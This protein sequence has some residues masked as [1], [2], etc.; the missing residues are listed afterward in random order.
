MYKG[1]LERMPA[2]GTA[3]KERSYSSSKTASVRYC[4]S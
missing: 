4:C 3:G 2:Q 1:R